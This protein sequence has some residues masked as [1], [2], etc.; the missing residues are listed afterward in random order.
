MAKILIVDDLHENREFLSAVLVHHGHVVVQA[1]DGAAA[2]TSARTN[3]PDL[4]ITDVL[5]PVMDGYEL[6]KQLRFDSTTSHI[7]VV[8]YTAHYGE[9]EATALALTSGVSSVLTKP[10]SSKE[11]IDTVNLV[12]RLDSNVD[13]A[14][15]RNAVSDSFNRDHLQLLTDKVSEK[16]SELRVANARLRAIINI[17]LEFSSERDADSRLDTVCASARDLFGASYAALGIFNGDGRTVLRSYCAGVDAPSWL[18][19][20]SAIQGMLSNVVATRRAI[21]GANP[22]VNAQHLRRYLITPIASPGHVYGWLCLVRVDGTEFGED[23]E[24]LV[25]ALSGQVGRIYELDN[26]ILERHRA[27]AE[28]QKQHDL[29]QLYLDTAEVLLL[30][31]DVE[32][33]ITMIN[34]NGCNLLGWTESELVGADFAEMCL[35]EGIRNELRARLPQL[36]A[37]LF[38]TSVNAVLTKSGA[39]R[40]IEW[41][42]TV[43]RDE[44]GG[45]TGSFSSGND[46]TEE[47]QAIGALRKAEERMRFA[48]K[49]A[50]VGI[51]DLDFIT[52]VLEWSDVLEEQYGLQPGTFPGTFDAFIECIHP[53]DRAA[54]LK[55]IQDHTATGGD[56]VILNRG[57][58]PTDQRGT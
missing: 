42:N 29:A 51:W 12:L 9:R 18:E 26:E 37:G 55:T 22:V 58:R 4:V 10:A 36:H 16:A 28:L 56:F 34:R 40:R 33:R 53:D 48:L 6:F 25:V 20:E 39:E 23:D 2:L 47:F 50:N 35:P 44:S 49:S 8:F 27:E 3:L 15:E 43:L 32:G 24:Q 13:P 21:R 52:G 11:V 45:V 17:G 14:A 30:G 54:A 19:T 31:L 38:P 57:V 46:I 1:G 5:M 7:P 41:H